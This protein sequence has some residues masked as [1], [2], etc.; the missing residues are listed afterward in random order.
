MELIGTI[1][2]LQIQRSSLKLGE[3][4]RR[5]FDPSPL[6]E[7]P[8]LSLSPD[9]RGELSCCAGLEADLG[10]PPGRSYGFFVFELQ[11]YGLK[12]ELELVSVIVGTDGTVLTPRESLPS[13]LN[14]ARSPR[15]S[16]AP[17]CLR[18]RCR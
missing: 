2:R 13:R 17:P 16:R 11:A 15:V 12:D 14:A 7:V 8:A 3:R 10:L 18:C 1:V 6:L 5:W 4:P 9:L